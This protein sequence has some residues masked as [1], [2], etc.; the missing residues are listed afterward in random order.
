[1]LK[2]YIIFDVRGFLKALNYM[3]NIFNSF[4]FTRFYCLT[5]KIKNAI[6]S[7]PCFLFKIVWRQHDVVSILKTS[8]LIWRRNS[9]HL[10]F[11]LPMNSFP[12]LFPFSSL[13]FQCQLRYLIWKI[14]IITLWHSQ[15]FCFGIP[16]L[17]KI[18]I[19]YLFASH[20]IKC[21]CSF[22]AMLI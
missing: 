20:H 2:G 9:L 11:R 13:L 3:L 10:T 16:I 17:S 21:F 4:I 18:M 1:M 19:G 14:L 5:F 8:T 22:I 6:K 12:F 7:I 15:R